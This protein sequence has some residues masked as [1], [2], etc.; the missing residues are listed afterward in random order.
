MKKKKL[1]PIKISV[2]HSIDPNPWIYY[3]ADLD[4]IVFI[5]PEKKSVELW[6]ERARS[7]GHLK[8][9]PVWSRLFFNLRS[10]EGTE[11][12]CLDRLYGEDA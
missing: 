2:E 10:N 4:E 11:V 5:Y 7:R 6:F 1:K 9:M 12:I 8:M 3:F